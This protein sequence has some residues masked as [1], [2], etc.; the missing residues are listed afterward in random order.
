MSTIKTLSPLVAVITLGTATLAGCSLLLGDFTE[1]SVD[2]DCTSKGP[3]LVCLEKMCVTDPDPFSK[4]CTTTLGSNDPDAITFGAIMAMTTTDGADNPRGEYRSK[5]VA[6][7]LSEIN[8]VG[9]AGHKFAVRVCNHQGDSTR[10]KALAQYLISQY[11]VPALMTGGSADTIEAASVAIE[12]GVSVMAISASSPAITSL[13]DDDLVWRIAPSDALLGAYVATEIGAG[14]NPL[15]KVAVL[16]VDDSYG[17]GLA[18]VFGE[19]FSGEKD[20]VSF[21]ADGSNLDDKLAYA[22]GQNPDR[23]FVVAFTENAAYIVNHLGNQSPGL[24]SGADLFFAD[25]MKDS[26][27]FA[28]IDDVNSVENARGASPGKP[29][30][31]VYQGFADRFAQTYGLDP[32]DQGYLA[33]SYDAMYSLALGAAWALGQVD[34]ALSGA[35]IAQG[36]AHLYVAGATSYDYKPADFSAMAAALQG[37]GDLDVRGASGELDFDPSTGE[38]PSASVT[39]WIYGGQF[40]SQPPAG[41]DAGVADAYVD[42]ANVT[43]A[44]I[45]DATR[46]DANVDAGVLD[47]SLG[48]A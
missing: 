2:A 22:A 25:S 42:D 19:N 39:W 23:L 27:F 43:D 30:G 38:A 29:E 8:Q 20:L 37:G 4:D 44:A 46:E 32:E 35:G 45:E 7:A 17:A 18:D 1:C 28:D 16:Y 12:Q 26:A 6:L 47:S 33:H 13:P 41:T 10:V 11:G 36:L 21:A 15:P 48:D 40:Q 9:V 5:A 31:D 3:G 24:P 34:G 14:V